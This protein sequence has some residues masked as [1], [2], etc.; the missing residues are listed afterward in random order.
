MRHAIFFEPPAENNYLGHI[1]EEVYKSGLY[2][3]FIPQNPKD[4]VVID[5]GGNIGITSY[6]FHDKFETIYTIEPS[7]NHFETINQML[8][9]NKITNVKPFQFALSNTD[10]KSDFFQY[11]DN[12]TMNSLYP[13]LIPNANKIEVPLKRLDTFFKEQNIDHVNLLKCDVEG[14]EFEVLCGDGFANV[15]DK[16]DAVIGEVHTFAGRD[17]NQIKDSLESKG[18]QFSWLPHDANLFYAKK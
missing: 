12:L 16:I 14:V 17:P 7:P 1:F 10:G 11:K 3:P 13:N 9:F 6:F 15:A 18:F 2:Q 4:T 5:A 8:S